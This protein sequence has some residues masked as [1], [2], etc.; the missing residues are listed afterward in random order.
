MDTRPG[1]KKVTINTILLADNLL[2][3]KDE[4]LTLEYFI[5]G[6]CYFIDDPQ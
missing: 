4:N 1:K 3:R 5:L 2:H 6:I